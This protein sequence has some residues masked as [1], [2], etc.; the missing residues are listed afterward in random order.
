MSAIFTIL[1]VLLLIGLFF[2]SQAGSAPKRTTKRI[3]PEEHRMFFA[4]HGEKGQ[5][6][7]FFAIILAVVIGYAWVLLSH[8]SQY[9]AF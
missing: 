7:P 8:A 6:L 4:A 5:A 2:L 9:S 1:F 3:S